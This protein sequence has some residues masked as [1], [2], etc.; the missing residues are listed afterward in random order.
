MVPTPDKLPPLSQSSQVALWGVPYGQ[1]TEEEKMILHDMQA[2]PQNGQ[3]QHDSP[4]LGH[5]RRTVVKGNSPSGQNFEQSSWLFPFS[6]REMPRWPI[7]YGFMGCGQWFGWMVR[8]LE[9]MWPENWRAG[10]LGRYVDRPLWIGKKCEDI[11]VPCECSLDTSQFLSPA[12]PVISQRA[13]EKSGHCGRSRGTH[14]LSHMDFHSPRLTWLWSPLSAWSAS[15]R[16][17]HWVP[18]MAP[19]PGWSAGWWIISLYL[20]P[21]PLS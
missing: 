20:Q 3:L 17:Q 5:R 7:I 13:H 10:N 4:S 21:R 6:E 1:L 8:D 18:I 2:I 19:F 14:E 15:S 12:T 9:G 11:C 16:D